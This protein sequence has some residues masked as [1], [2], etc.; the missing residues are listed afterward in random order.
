MHSFKRFK[1]ILLFIKFLFGSYIGTFWNLFDNE[2]RIVK[3]YDWNEQQFS[4]L[5]SLDPR[6]KLP[7]TSV[8]DIF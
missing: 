6:V 2:C 3:Y 7:V 4:K 1:E 8:M 5:I